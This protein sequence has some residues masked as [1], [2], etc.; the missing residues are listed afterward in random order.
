MK[1]LII[2]L[3]LLFNLDTYAQVLWFNDYD[4]ASKTALKE[5]KFIVMDFWAT[6]CGPCVEMDR[7]MWGKPEMNS[8][9]D[10]FIPLKIDVDRNRTLA[11]KFGATSIPKVVIIDPA[12]NV[13]WQQVGFSTPTPYMKIFKQLPKNSIPVDALKKEI[14]SEGDEN[15]WNLLAIS[16]QE[17][18]REASSTR[19][20][21]GFL[22]LSDQYFTK[23][24]KKSSNNDMILNSRLNLVL[25]DAYRGK[26]KSALKQLSK[27]SEGNSDLKNYIMAYC[28]KCDG[29]IE[30]MNKY[31]NLI[32]NPDYLA[33]LD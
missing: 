27:L 3:F 21:S 29:Q 9:A 13:I 19:L 23:V 20:N 5:N 10:N 12:G 22:K 25:N 14:A 24:K 6:W 28:Y 33:Q 11:S 31:K 15:S 16:Y 2:A 18:G 8:L 4:F 7:E 26:T 32:T 17:L 1:N 30:E